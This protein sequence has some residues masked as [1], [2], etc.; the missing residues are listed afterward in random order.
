MFYLFFV[1]FRWL[2]GITPSIGIAAGEL[3]GAIFGG[4]STILNNLLRPLV[5]FLDS[6]LPGI[7]AIIPDLA[8]PTVTLGSLSLAIP[9]VW[10]GEVTHVESQE[11][12]VSYSVTAPPQAHVMGRAIA[13]MGKS[14]VP[15][16]LDVS[17]RVHV[18][19]GIYGQTTGQLIA[20]DYRVP[21]VYEG[22]KLINTEFLIDT[23]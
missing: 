5:T 20:F 19:A 1:F 7:A 9:L 11:I 3:P 4:L 12:V 21:G 10:S 23:V 14:S 16:T 18:P 6:I 2:V 15:F 22:A 13:H 8:L 17:R